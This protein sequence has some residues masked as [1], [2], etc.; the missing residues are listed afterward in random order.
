MNLKLYLSDKNI[1]KINKVLLLREKEFNY[2]RQ[3][4]FQ[5]KKTYVND[6]PLIRLKLGKKFLKN[7]LLNY[8]L[9]KFIC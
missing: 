9:N 2:R 5:M 7:K 3:I 4:Y 1:D 8:I 6:N